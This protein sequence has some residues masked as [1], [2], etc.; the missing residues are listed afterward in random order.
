MVS[1]VG[2]RVHGQ[3]SEVSDVIPDVSGFVS[4]MSTPSFLVLVALA[5]VGVVT[6]VRKLARTVIVVGIIG[7][8]G[9]WFVSSR[10]GELTF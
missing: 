7:A 4:D 2:V 1:G 3:A 9:L 8:L 10:V 5:V 6:L